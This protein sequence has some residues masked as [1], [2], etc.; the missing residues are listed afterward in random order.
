VDI[1]NDGAVEINQLVSALSPNTPYHWRVRTKYDLAKTPF[2]KNGPWM[3][4]PVNGWNEADLRTAD[5]T[6]GIETAEA[7]GARLLLETPRPNPFGASAEIVY[8]LSRSGRVRLAIYD[9]TGRERV[10]LADA[11]QTAGRQVATW[12]GRGERGA[13][14]PAGVYFVRLAFDG[15]VETQKLVLA[16]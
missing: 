5:A 4:V 10:V 13:A 1:G 14:L 12:D 15:H 11:M 9:V 3:H 8:T 16:R 2:Q 7:P 6:A